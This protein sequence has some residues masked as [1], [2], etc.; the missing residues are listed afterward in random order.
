MRC[1]LFLM[2]SL[3]ISAWCQAKQ[4]AITFDDAPRK[5]TGYFDGPTRAK[6]L[7]DNLKRHKVPE[8]AFFVTTQ[9]MNQEGRQRIKAYNNAGHLIANHTHSHPDFLKQDLDSYRD[10]FLKAHTM[11]KGLSQFKPWFRF[12]YLREGETLQKRDG[13]RQTLAEFGYTNAY[14]T[15]NNYDWYIENLFQQALAAGK[16][17]NFARL[18]E[19]YVDSIMQSID[20]YD[21]MAEH[22]LGRSPKHVLLLHEMDISALFIGDLVTRLRKEGWE[23]ISPEVA[24]RDPIAT[25]SLPTPRKYNPGRIGEI[26]YSKGQRKGLWHYSLDEAYLEK[27][28]DQEVLLLSH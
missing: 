23:I 2:L 12:P 14:I 4:L 16:K 20:Y 6:T 1:A 22:H 7:I 18:S 28:F 9:G 21:A 13:M 11:L 15:L 27:R 17:V 10:D 19:M 26:A 24:Y 25:F 3:V 8:V 5:A